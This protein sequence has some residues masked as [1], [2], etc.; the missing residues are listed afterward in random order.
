MV[1]GIGNPDR[2]DDGAG[3]AVARVLGQMA[4]DG[5]EIVEATGEVT[6]LLDLMA[7]SATVYVVDACLSGA[8]P[9]TIRR[10]DARERPL[11]ENTFA[12]STHGLGLAQAIELARTLGQLPRQCIVF[13]I[14]GAS[15]D[16]GAALSPPV[17]KAV[18]TVAFQLRREIAAMISVE[19]TSDA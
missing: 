5:A 10:F 2:G 16:I 15:F 1:V 19:A 18:F 13:A 11:P 8:A 12:T 17:D 4:P 6:E 14:E 9:G 7:R 3:R